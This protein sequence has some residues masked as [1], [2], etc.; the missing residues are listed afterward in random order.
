MWAAR[1]W[2]SSSLVSIQ[3][4]G[5]TPPDPV[6]FVSGP[7]LRAGVAALACYIP[8]RSSSFLTAMPSFSLR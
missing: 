4:F 6:V 8:A 5:V 3:L 2:A 7:A 1:V